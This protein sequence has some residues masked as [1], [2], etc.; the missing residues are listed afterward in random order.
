MSHICP[1]R[2]LN[3][4]YLVIDLNTVLEMKG[5]GRRGKGDLGTGENKKMVE[6]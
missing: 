5:R 3:S 2:Q 1:G 6:N 4:K